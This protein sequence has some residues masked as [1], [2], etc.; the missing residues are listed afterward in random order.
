MDAVFVSDTHMRHDRLSIPRCDLLVHA[1]D[2][3]RRGTLA[4]L[5]AVLDWIG[6]QPAEARI[7]VAGNHDRCCEE[8]PRAVRHA[9]RARGIHYLCDEGI[10]IGGRRIWGS[11]VTPRFRNMAFNRDRGPT[12][13]AHWSGIPDGLDLLVTHGPPRGAGDRTLVGLRV[14]CD[15]L[16]QAV[17]ARRPRWHVFGHIHED[18]GEHRIEG[19]PTRL[20]NVAS[21]RWAPGRVRAPVRMIF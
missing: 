17:V 18:H 6:A 4:E 11:P 2:A 14:G 13:G 15:D 12:I 7:F 21:A 8:D 20:F 9:C 1:G 3:T 10:E 5:L 16:R 19:T